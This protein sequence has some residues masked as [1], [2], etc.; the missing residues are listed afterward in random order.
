MDEYDGATFSCDEA[1]ET[2]PVL[3]VIC[4]EFAFWDFPE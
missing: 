3:L 4:G 1:A 2:T